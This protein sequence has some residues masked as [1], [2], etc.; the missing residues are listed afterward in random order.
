[1]IRIEELA[2]GAGEAVRDG[3][4][5]EVK[6]AG[7]FPDGKTFDSGKFSFKVGGG[8]VIQGFDMGVTG[9]KKGGKRRVTIPPELGYGAQGAGG[10]IPPNATLVFD[11]EVLSFK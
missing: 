11:L 6:Y 3:H 1:M 4:N 10:A 9:M 5:V 7:S 2:E 8:Q